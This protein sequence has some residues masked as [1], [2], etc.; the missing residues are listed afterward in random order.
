MELGVVSDFVAAV[1][2]FFPVPKALIGADSASTWTRGYGQANLEYKL[3]LPIEVE[4]EQRGQYLMI[5]AYPNNP[6]MMFKIGMKFF[7]HIVCRLDFELEAT[8]GNNFRSWGDGLPPVVVGPHWHKWSL[9]RTLVTSLGFPLQLHNAVPFEES[10]KFDATLRA[11][12][13]D[14]SINLGRHAIELP[15]R[16]MLI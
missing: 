11:Y 3:L 8:H 15:Q 14:W 10:K 2:E 16:D 1:D 13:S 5:L 4:G 9:N 12:C 7:D 6:T